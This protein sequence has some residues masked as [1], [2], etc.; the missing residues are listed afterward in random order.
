MLLEIPDH[1][2][3]IAAAA[4]FGLVLS[5]WLIVALALSV[6]RALR[7][8]KVERRL[9]LGQDEMDPTRVVRLWHDGQETTTTV[10]EFQSTLGLWRRLKHRLDDSGWRTPAIWIL[11][12][13]LGGATFISVLVWLAVG[14]VLPALAAGIAVVVIFFVYTKVRLDRQVMLFEK[15]FADALAMIARFLRAGQPL[16]S[17]FQLASEQLPHPVCEVFGE[18]CQQHNFG[19]TMDQALRRVSDKYESRDLRLFATAVIIQ[20]HSGGNLAQLMDRLSQVIRDRMRLGRRV[21][22]LTAQTRLST[23]IL[24][25]LP[26]V[27]FLGINLI[28]PHYMQPLY[29]TTPGKLMLVMGASS[30]LLGVWSMK[31]LSV[32]R[33]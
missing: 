18:I 4:V 6:R 14:S 5:L 15:Q 7:I 26:F 31:W 20:L 27:V 24:I 1:T 28:N 29:T 33:Y 13:L 8:Q 17:G 30:L 23:R 25:V 11:L 21:R 16:L 32:L 22:V 19:V 10:P 3:L 9:G 12:A 2:E